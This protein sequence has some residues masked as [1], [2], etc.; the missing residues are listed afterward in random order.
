MQKKIAIIGTAPAS[1]GLAPY[2]ESDWDIWACSPGNRQQLPRVT[3]WFELHALR[4]M[5]APE[6]RGM[7]EPYFAW[8]KEQSDGDKFQVVMQEI[9]DLVPR[10]IPFPLHEMLVKYG[11]NW[12]AST[13]A[14]MM[15]LAIERGAAD[16][17]LWGVDMAADLEQYTGQRASCIRF[18]EIAKERGITVHIPQESCLAEPPP[19]YGYSEATPMARR[20]NAVLQLANGQR[21][22]LAAAVDRNRL[23]T[24]FFDGAIEQLKYFQRTWVDGSE[25]SLNFG[26]LSDAAKVY[27]DKLTGSASQERNA[28]SA[29][30]PAIIGGPIPMPA[31]AGPV[32]PPSVTTIA[33]SLPAALT[34]APME[35]GAKAN[36]SGHVETPYPF[37]SEAPQPAAGAPA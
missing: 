34:E 21:A 9:N 29:P 24:A 18:M 8:L 27:A 19:L 30:L 36:G 17:G 32:A 25:A 12:F 15:A 37:Q 14:Y 22:A 10:A 3:V 5:M 23:E 1:V 4:E 7:A 35:P 13:I 28:K 11:H 6:N 2:G 20:I 33:P 16:I 31:Q 26:A